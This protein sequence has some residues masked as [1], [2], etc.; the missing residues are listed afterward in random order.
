MARV[1]IVDDEAGYRRYVSQRLEQDGHTVE[2]AAHGAEG[3]DVGATFHPDLLIVDWMLH[4]D[5]TGIEVAQALR[6]IDPDMRTILI[7]G[8]PSNRLRR[9]AR[10]A[11]VFR[12]LEKPFDL[13][14]LEEAVRQALEARKSR[15]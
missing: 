13:E 3:I 15:R 8:Y 7:T 4:N 6:E 2:T 1:L 9:M 10:E 5:Y 11:E 12:F 14:T